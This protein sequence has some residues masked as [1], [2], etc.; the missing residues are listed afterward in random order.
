MLRYRTKVRIITG[1]FALVLAASVTTGVA[2]L[3]TEPASAHTT[4]CTSAG[5]GGVNEW[6]NGQIRQNGNHM[7]P[8]R[9]SFA[10]WRCANAFFPGGGSLTMQLQFIQRNANGTCS[11]THHSWASSAPTFTASG[12]IATLGAN[13]LAHTCHRIWWRANNAASAW[14]THRGGI[15]FEH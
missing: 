2:P 3:T 8:I 4:I 12:Q 10:Q 9:W 1:L 7:H 11:S 6:R 14:V 5:A 13:V 15:V